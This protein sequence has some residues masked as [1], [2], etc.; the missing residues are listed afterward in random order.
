MSKRQKDLLR[1]Y[2]NFGH[3]HPT[4]PGSASGRTTA[5][6]GV[7]VRPKPPFLQT[8]PNM[9]SISIVLSCA[10]ERKQHLTKLV[11][12]AILY[13]DMHL[14]VVAITTHAI[15][16]THTSFFFTLTT[17]ISFVARSNCSRQA[18]D[19]FILHA[20]T[21]KRVFRKY[22]HRLPAAVAPP[23]NSKTLSHTKAAS[24]ALYNFSRARPLIWIIK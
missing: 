8:L 23:W 18:H 12:S 5:T 20:Q 17:H 7:S 3:P 14:Q 6:V 9:P 19:V 21:S 10:A 13:R 15:I 16:Y 11:H 24:K 22:S 2:T 4:G 1:N